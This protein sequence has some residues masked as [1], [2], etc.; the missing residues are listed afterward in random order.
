MLSLFSFSLVVL[1]TRLRLLFWS[2]LT[3]TQVL[4]FQFA[5]LYSCYV[6]MCVSVCVCV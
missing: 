4:L 6:H 5:V 1:L 2:Y 3:R